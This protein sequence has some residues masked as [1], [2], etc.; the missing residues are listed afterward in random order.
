[1]KLVRGRMFVL[2]AMPWR[3]HVQWLRPDRFRRRKRG[4]CTMPGRLCPASR[5]AQSRRRS[6]AGRALRHRR[7]GTPL[8][9]VQACLPEESRQSAL[10][11]CRG[12][13]SPKAPPSWEAKR[14][15]RCSRALAHE[16][17]T[18][19]RR[20]PWTGTGAGRQD[21]C[22]RR[23]EP[24]AGRQLRRRCQPHRAEALKGGPQPESPRNGHGW[25]HGRSRLGMAEPRLA[26]RGALVHGRERRS[27]RA[28][29]KPAPAA[30]ITTHPKETSQWPQA[31]ARA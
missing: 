30:R 10:H 13:R 3:G 1:M 14:R 23:P 18:A 25:P 19:R 27:R 21:G 31:A 29:A 7:D 2:G 26:F 4:L 16:H 20:R 9:T 28:G 17:G 5:S 11:S 15:P 6:G 12:R 24:C 22:A 8:V